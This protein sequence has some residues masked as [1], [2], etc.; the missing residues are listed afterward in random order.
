M[1]CCMCHV[2]DAGV[3]IIWSPYIKQTPPKKSELIPPPFL[4]PL[5]IRGSLSCVWKG[6][7]FY[8]IV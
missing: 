4:V 8:K 1:I 3:C 6:S 5:F 2:S 7:F